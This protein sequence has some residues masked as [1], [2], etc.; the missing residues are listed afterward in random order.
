MRCEF[1]GGLVKWHP[2][3]AL[4]GD[5]VKWCVRCTCCGATSPYP[6]PEDDEDDDEDE[7]LETADTV[8]PGEVL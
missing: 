1:C 5:R 6:P 2:L 4:G 3:H 7:D 8:P